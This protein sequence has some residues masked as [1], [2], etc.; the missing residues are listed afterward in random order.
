MVYYNN[1]LTWYQVLTAYRMYRRSMEINTHRVRA[2][3][4]WIS[5]CWEPSSWNPCHTKM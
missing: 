4:R 5:G 3:T 1:H 2:K